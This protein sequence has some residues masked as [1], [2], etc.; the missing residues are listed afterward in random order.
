MQPFL[1]VALVRAYD[2]LFTRELHPKFQSKIAPSAVD[3]AHDH[4]HAPANS[5]SSRCCDNGE[6]MHGHEHTDNDMPERMKRA[7]AKAGHEHA[8]SHD[9]AHDH[10]SE[11][12]RALV[13]A[14]SDAVE[15]RGE[16][17]A[18]ITDGDG[19]TRDTDSGRVKCT[20]RKRTRTTTRTAR[21]YRTVNI[22]TKFIIDRP[23]PTSLA[24]A[25]I[26]LTV[27]V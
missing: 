1:D 24:K 27:Q 2:A 18:A 20:Y 3:S 10:G 14:F 25:N 7:M 13:G 4:D 8:H 17:Q 5:F 9:H 16:P 23:S 19:A 6:H 22:E 12:M 15:Q 21:S 26:L 11:A